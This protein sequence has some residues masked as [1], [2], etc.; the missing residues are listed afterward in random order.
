M[1][2]WIGIWSWGV[3]SW[4][5]GGQESWFLKVREHPC[6]R[7]Y[8]VCDLKG[9]GDTILSWILF[10]QNF[11]WSLRN[12]MCAVKHQGWFFFEDTKKARSSC[13]SMITF[14]IYLVICISH[15]LQF[16]WSI[17]IF[18]A[19]KVVLVVQIKQTHS[20]QS[21]TM[22]VE[23]SSGAQNS[24]SETSDTFSL[25]E[26]SEVCCVFSCGAYLVLQLRFMGVFEDT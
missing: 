8:A 12:E 10:A 18:H 21:G 4:G 1:S 25:L 14:Y 5:L 20:H 26:V 9:T 11:R 15:H 19:S 24:S 17:N 7:A 3:S 23:I 16:A 6:W 2:R 13:K 22:A